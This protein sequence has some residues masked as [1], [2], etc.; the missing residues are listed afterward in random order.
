MRVEPDPDRTTIT[1]GETALIIG[2]FVACVVVSGLLILGAL[3]AFE[4]LFH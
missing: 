2:T 1:W 4:G 3:F